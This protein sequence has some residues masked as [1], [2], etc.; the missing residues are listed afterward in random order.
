MSTVRLG[1]ALV[2]T[3]TALFIVATALSVGTAQQG[4]GKKPAGK[5]GEKKETAPKGDLPSIEIEPL[6]EKPADTEPADPKTPE[7]PPKKPP[8]GEKKPPTKKP[9]VKKP[10]RDEDA[11]P[12]APPDADCA[13]CLG[14]GTVPVAKRVPYV[15]VEGDRPPTAAFC[16]PWAFCP[17][18]Q[19]GRDAAE[20]V[21]LEAQRLQN[22][23]ASHLAWEKLSKLPLVRVETRH[24]TMHAQ[25]T[26]DLARKQGVAAE[27]LITHLQ[28][29]TRSTVL[30]QTRPPSFELLY[31]WDDPTYI[32]M[33]NI[34]KTMEEFR[35]VQDWDLVSKTL[36]FEGRLGE[37]ANAKKGGPTPPEHFI[38]STVGLH[39]I[40]AA[41]HGHGKDWLEVGFAYYCENA[42]L[43]KILIQYVDYQINET[44]L[45]PNWINETKKY[46]SEGKLIP[47]DDMMDV[48]VRDWRPQHH[49]TAFSSV[50]FLMRTDPRRFTR[51]VVAV[52]KGQDQRAALEQIYGRSL[53]EIEAL[54][55]RGIAA[56][57]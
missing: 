8:T 43:N 35:N 12:D 19:P 51:Y 33:I 27:N 45:G 6:P 17:K 16:V 52:G 13:T 10:P 28:Q 5:K 9:P 20:L 14:T 56:A 46:A 54:Y 49:L 21:E 39:Q 3:F 18:C 31:V 48:Q 57:Q 15:H 55:R 29:I 4:S 50:T 1:R 47:W 34:C 38:T 36:S 11:D 41:T 26:P 44:H 40:N 53:K 30:T 23:G 42:L 7:K 25:M 32:K 22:V 24:F 2:L 37:V